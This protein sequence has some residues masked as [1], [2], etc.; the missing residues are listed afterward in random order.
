M[1]AMIRASHIQTPS[2]VLRQPWRGGHRFSQFPRHLG[3][4]EQV[5]ARGELRHRRSASGR[6]AF[7]LGAADRLPAR[8]RLRQR[9][10]QAVRPDPPRRSSRYAPL[11]N[12]DRPRVH[13]VGARLDTIDIRRPPPWWRSCCCRGQQLLPGRLRIAV[14]ASDDVRRVSWTAGVSY[15]M[16]LGL[17][18]SATFSGQATVIWPRRRT[19]HRGYRRGLGVRCVHVARV[20]SEEQPAERYALLHVGP[21]RTGAH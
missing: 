21:L 1:G 20:R 11:G 17:V 6:A 4:G 2:R 5:G 16:P 8:R 19:F 14:A 9:T 10:L 15:A 7:T 3:A 18:P 13:R 12:A